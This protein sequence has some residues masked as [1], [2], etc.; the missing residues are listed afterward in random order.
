MVGLEAAQA[1]FE[2]GQLVLAPG[3]ALHAGLALQLR[4]EA[5]ACGDR[6][7]ACG[8]LLLRPKEDLLRLPE[9]R[10]ALLDPRQPLFVGVA[11]RLLALGD[12]GFSLV[13]LARAAVE[14]RSAC[15]ELLLGRRGLRPAQRREWRS[16][17]GSRESVL[18]LLLALAHGGNPLAQLSLEPLQLVGSL[19]ALPVQRGALVLERPGLVVPPLRSSATT[20]S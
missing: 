18:E 5:F 15:G 10:E 12:G 20:P 8:E 14:R 4:D 9:L 7:A 11:G 3:V 19:Q 13:E 1:P 17:A 2:L 6:F 16:A